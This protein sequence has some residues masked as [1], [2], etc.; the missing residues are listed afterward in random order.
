[1]V[2]MIPCFTLTSS[3]LPT[4]STVIFVKTGVN[5]NG[6]S[7]NSPRG[8]LGA[9]VTNLQSAGGGTL[10]VC[11]PLEL[12]GNIVLGSGSANTVIKV[13]SVY[14]GVDYREKENGGAVLKFT[15]SWIN[16]SSKCVFEYENITFEMNGANCS[17]YA[18]GYPIVMGKGIKTVF[19]DGY[20]SKQRAAYPSV[21]GGSAF[22]LSATTN[23]PANT[24]VTVI[25]GDYWNIYGGGKGTADKQ[26]PSNSATVGISPDV[27][28]KGDCGWAL[29]ENGEILGAKTFIN[30]GGE[31]TALKEKFAGADK[32]VNVSG[33][34][35]ATGIEPGKL[36]IY[37]DSGFGAKIDGEIRKNG[38]YSF[39]ASTLGISFEKSDINRAEELAA[40]RP[41]LPSTFPGEYIKGYDNGDGTF[42][43][44]P[45]GNITIAEASTILVRLMTTEEKIKGK[46]ETDKAQKTD[47]FY[48]NIAYLDTYEAFEGFENFDGNRQITRAEFVK[49]VSCFRSFQ[50]K[51]NEIK[52]TDVSSDYKYYDAIKSATMA[53]IVNGYD[54]GDGTFSFKPDSPITRAE[55]VTVINRI[56]DMADLAPI[57]YKGMIPA[58]SDVE[59]SHWAAFQVIAAAGGKEKEPEKTDLKGTG[60]VEHTVEGTVIFAKDGGNK[61]ADGLTPETALDYNTASGKITDGGTIVV[62]GPVEFNSNFYFTKAHTGTILITSIYDG[63]DYRE[64][65]NAAFIFGSNW[66]N[67]VPGGNVIFDNIAFISRGTNCSVYCDNHK[68]V[69]GK[70]VVTVVES[71]NSIGIYGGS[72]FDLG[73]TRNY[74]GS[75]NTSTAHTG[76]YFGNV[77]I[78]SGTWGNV[79]AGGKATDAKP[80]EAYAAAI[81]IYGT[82]KVGTISGGAKEGPAKLHGLRAVVLNNCDNI[83]LGN[84]EYDILVNV[85]GKANVEIYDVAK[86]KI[87]FKVIN[88]DGSN[89]DGT[90]NGLLV[91]DKEATVNVTEENGKAKIEVTE[92]TDGGVL[93]DKMAEEV[94][95]EYLKELDALEAK[96][97]AE[98]KATKTEIKPADGKTAY[99]VSNKGDDAND[100]KS[101]EKAWKT[102]DKINTANLSQGD[103]VYLERGGEWRGTAL[104]TKAGVSYSAY[105]E[106]EKP[107]LNMS[108]YDGAKHGTWTLVEGTENIYKYSET[109]TNDIG[110]ISFNNRTFIDIYA[111]KMCYDWS[112]TKGTDRRNNVVCVEFADFMANMKNDLDFWHD[113]GGANIAAPSGKGQLYLRSDKGNPAQ[114]FTNIE[115]N[116]RISAISIG[117]SSVTIDNIT[118]R[119]PGVHG[120][121]SGTTNNLTVTNCTFEWIGGSMQHYKDGKFT[122][123]GNAVEIYGG[124]DGYLVDNCYIE[125]CYDAGV[126]H[127]ISHEA[128]G[129]YIMKNVTY[130][131]NVILR[132]IYS[133]EHFNRAREGT[134]RYL[135]N[136]LYKNNLCRLAGDCFGSTRPD[137]TV[138]SHIRSGTIVDTANFVIENNV[139]DRSTVQLFKLQ[140]GGDEEIQWKN[141]VYIHR[142]GAYY[143]TMKGV[144][145]VYNSNI[146]KEIEKYFKHPEIGGKYLFIK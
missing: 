12:T 5:G 136:I 127:Q 131:N 144:T 99:Y 128:S 100:G 87:T 66:R 4:S 108:P 133:I 140:A 80:R 18:N 106:G 117:G 84:E 15:K 102:I 52:F 28:V 41:V 21:Y 134:T 138:A 132:C 19:A 79:T 93:E 90:D 107:I 37:A 26:R 35:Y 2:T 115:F 118:V 63:V 78:E 24:S 8:D 82:A 50:Q 113:C 70:D 130:S 69:F 6:S 129:D 14:D 124:C 96:R 40:M 62:C 85:T 51:I 43:F 141:N 59:E 97:I 45:S 126:T 7:A 76:N 109:F 67:G 110:S 105:G 60:E 95:D 74:I 39:D 137:K 31:N 98:I 81:N 123:L 3:A 61:D 32:T 143:G 135:V 9:A 1:M 23:Y 92:K 48:D 88:E 111:Q 38:E 57:K 33:N 94:S 34:G 36:M 29:S 30:L 58:F 122:R 101:P 53:K 145:V 120:V 77:T 73:A 20:D 72:A 114:R 83:L 44:K 49:L 25:S 125:Q 91:L 142:L 71:G 10:V 42:S 112:G 86:D 116:P 54:N 64:T 55:V 104:R 68:V 75:E 103:V 46:N 11:G 119:H 17:F 89:A 139:F 22:D 146:S 27:T 121:S 16:V 65:A 13:T 47:W 56:F